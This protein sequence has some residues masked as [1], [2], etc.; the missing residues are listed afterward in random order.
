MFDLEQGFRKGRGTAAGMYVLRQMVGKR[1]EVQGS[2]ALGFVDLEKAFDTVPREMV[3]ATLRWMGVPVAEVRM[4]EG[5]YEKTTARVVVGEGA[6]E[7]F[8]VKI[9]LRQ[10]SVL[11]PL[12]FIAVLDLIS[13]NTVVKDAMKK[14][15]YA[16]DLALVANGKQELQETNGE[17]ERFV[18]QTRAET[19]PRE[20]GSAAH[21]PPKGRAEHRAGGEETDITGQFRVPRRGSVRRR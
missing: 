11:S 14:L 12:L 21:R 16:D 1:L 9:G 19:Q 20:D 2:M 10:G 6:S 13:S 8:G 5:T 17:V 15:L 18:Y 7:E 4:V 3:M